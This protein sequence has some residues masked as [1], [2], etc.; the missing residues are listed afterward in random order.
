MTE[1]VAYADLSDDPLVRAALLG[2]REGAE[3]VLFAEPGGLAG[4][5]ARR[6]LGSSGPFA[7]AARAGLVDDARLQ[8]AAAELDRLGAAAHGLQL[9]IAGP[10]DAGGLAGR[11]AL[12]D[13]WG[14]HAGELAAF[15][16]R[17]GVGEIGRAHV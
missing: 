5:L 8:I 12:T 11:L 13:G 14:R 10:A 15:H 16:E 2:D 6:V 3:R 7:R 9:R 1:L 4:G 17:E